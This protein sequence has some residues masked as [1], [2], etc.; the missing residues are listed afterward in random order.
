MAA[1]LQISEFDSEDQI[2]KEIAKQEETTSLKYIILRKD[3]RFGRKDAHPLEGK[4]ISWEVK[5]HPFNGVPFQVVGTSTYECHQGKDRQVKAKEKHAAKM[6]K[7]ALEDHALKRR[8]QNT[9]KVDCKALIN[10]AH[11]IRFPGFKIEESTVRSKKEASKDLKA[12]L[13]EKPSSVKAEVVYCVRFPSLSEHSSHALVGERSS[14]KNLKM[15]QKQCAGYLKEITDLTYH[16]QDEQYMAGLSSHLQSL[17]QEMKGLVPQD[18]DL[19]L[20]LSPRKRKAEEDMATLPTQGASQP[21]TDS[22]GQHADL[23]NTCEEPCLP[24]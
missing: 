2:T 22:V 12:A 17:L 4:K 8:K 10:I 1:T 16:L 13:S 24:N 18:K 19:T 3:K 6:N 5:S 15:L 9:K 21:F 20:T 14:K 11:I 7:K 23:Q